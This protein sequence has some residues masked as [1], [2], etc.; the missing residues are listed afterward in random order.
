MRSH[1]KHQSASPPIAPRPKGHHWLCVRGR[2]RGRTF[3]CALWSHG[4]ATRAWRS[5][6]RE[7]K[8]AATWP[9]L[10]AMATFARQTGAF[11]IAEAIEDEE[12]LEFLRTIDDTRLES[13]LV[14]QG[15]QASGSGEHHHTSCSNRPTCCAGTTRAP[16]PYSL[17]RELV[18]TAKGLRRPGRIQ[19]IGRPV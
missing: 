4:F 1:A 10:M 11:V 12:T 2:R 9:I 18:A 5:A 15:G 6:I 13:D 7:A 17:R 8:G 16:C 19:R 3:D 14:I